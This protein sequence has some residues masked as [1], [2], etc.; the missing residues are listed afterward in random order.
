MKSID[1]IDLSGGFS[2]ISN[3]W[4]LSLGDKVDEI[5]AKLLLLI[6]KLYYQQKDVKIIVP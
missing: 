4:D 3:I 5:R 1:F 2:H 6:A